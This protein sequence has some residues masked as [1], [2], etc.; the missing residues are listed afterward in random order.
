WVESSA[1]YQQQREILLQNIEYL[2]KLTTTFTFVAGEGTPVFVVAKK[3]IAP[4]LLQNN[5]IISSF[6]YPHPES[7]P[8]NRV[9]VNALHLISDLE[10]LAQLIEQY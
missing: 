3:G 5:V 1:L 8:V 6:S 7:D 9:V 4:Y 2:Q 10:K